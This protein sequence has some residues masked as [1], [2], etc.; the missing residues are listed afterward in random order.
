MWTPTEGGAHW[1]LATP[2]L[3]GIEPLMPTLSMVKATLPSG[4]PAP[5]TAWST[6]GVPT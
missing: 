6:V 2:L 4:M 1:K 3:V 5:S